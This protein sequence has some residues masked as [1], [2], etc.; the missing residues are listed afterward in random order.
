MEIELCDSL[1]SEKYIYV[2][3][4]LLN[5]L[6]FKMVVVNFWRMY[7]FNIFENVGIYKR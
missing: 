6:Y 1:L 5:W 2:W 4:K 7:V 3:N